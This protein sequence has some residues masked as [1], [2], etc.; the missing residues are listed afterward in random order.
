[1][2]QVKCRNREAR[3]GNKADWLGTGLPA[4]CSLIHS[5]TP[6]TCQDSLVSWALHRA[7]PFCKNFMLHMHWGHNTQHAC[8]THPACIFHVQWSQNMPV[9]CKSPHMQ[10]ACGPLTC[11][12]HVYWS[13]NMHVACLLIKKHACCM[14]V[15]M[16][17]TCMF[18]KPAYTM[19][20]T[21]MLH[22]HYFM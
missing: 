7:G 11:M 17:A 2:L 4:H 10:D 21:C 1:M 8:S 9:T 19:H 16:N 3:S 20:K 6:K 12:L 13:G 18:F 15:A 22:A 5:H 14:Q